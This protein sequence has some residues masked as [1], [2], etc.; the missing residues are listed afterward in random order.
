M[1]AGGTLVLS[2]DEVRI[3]GGLAGAGHAEVLV[4]DS[5]WAAE[6]QSV[7][8]VVATRGLLARGLV[9]LDTVLLPAAA[10]TAADRHASQSTT[11][12][13]AALLGTY[14]LAPE[15]AGMVAGVLTRQQA[16]TTVRLTGHLGDL[17]MPSSPAV[18]PVSSAG[19]QPKDSPSTGSRS[20]A[21]R[22]GS[23]W[24]TAAPSSSPAVTS[25]GCGWVS[26]QRPPSCPTDSDAY[27]YR[28]WVSRLTRDST[29]TAG[30]T[31][32]RGSSARTSYWPRTAR[33]V[34]IG[35][36]QCSVRAAQ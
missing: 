36:S 31:G 19:A 28:P 34:R 3:L 27:Q 25:I 16:V 8:D 26:H 20:S 32:T 30:R 12:A 9:H 33:V 11:E 35:R 2:S 6:D 29:Q 24:P 10:L 1:T 14:G 5:G 22:G 15:A 21:G 17:R 18:R 13:V 7:A 23:T 4:P